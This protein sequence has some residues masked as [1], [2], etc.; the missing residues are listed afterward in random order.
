[1]KKIMLLTCTLTI[2]LIYSLSSA[3]PDRWKSICDDG[4]KQ[5]VL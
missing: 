3:V 5:N 4:P 1:M 2:V